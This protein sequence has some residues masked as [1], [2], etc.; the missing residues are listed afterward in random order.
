MP[1]FAT[2]RR[3]LRRLRPA[4]SVVTADDV[5]RAYLTLLGRLPESEYALRAAMMHCPTVPDLVRRITESPEFAKRWAAAPVGTP[6]DPDRPRELA[7]DEDVIAAFP[8][9][10]GPGT[11][12]FIT[13]F[14]G[15][16]TR[17]EFVQGLAPWDGRVEGP[18]VP[19]NFHAPAVEWAGVLRSVLDARD[20]YAA[21]ELGAGW[22][23][24]LVAAATAAARRGITDVTLVG[25]EAAA[26][27]HAFLRQHLADNGLDPDRHRLLHGAATPADGFVEFPDLDDAAADYGATLHTGD[28]LLGRAG[29]AGRRVPG[30]SLATLLA[31]LEAADLV[32]IDIQGS[33]A[34]VVSAGRDVLRAKAR[35][36]VIGTHGRSVEQRLLE[37][38][39]ADGWVLESDRA[40]RYAPNATGLG[41]AEDG[42]QVW[43]N[44]G[45]RSPR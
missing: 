21:V 7:T 35:R 45:A 43:R 39:S 26:A 37:E 13:D 24:W 31:P 28:A 10:R 34:E 41:L 33:E 18:P 25:L 29:G 14:L 2:V 12:G 36:L 38:L 5:K 8:P 42:C 6:A 23:P 19:G 44:P 15:V 4:P 17:V 1:R 40:C 32:H 9:Y 16:R 27:H 11:P 20:R 3:V 22:G 30:Y